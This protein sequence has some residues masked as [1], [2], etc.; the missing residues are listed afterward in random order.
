M[1]K[2]TNNIDRVT[3][4]YDWAKNN[5]TEILKATI[6][7][8]TIRQFYNQADNEWGDWHNG[9]YE[10]IS[11]LIDSFLEINNQAKEEYINGKHSRGEFAN[12]VFAKE[13]SKVYQCYRFLKIQWL[14]NSIKQD[15]QHAPIQLMRFRDTQYRFHPGSDKIHSLYM[16]ARQKQLPVNL[17]YIWYKDLDPHLPSNID[18]DV[19]QT[20]D[21]FAKMF[22]KFND[23]RFKTI[24][25]HA[26]INK[27]DWTT[28]QVHFNVFC[29]FVS[30]V[31]SEA[32]D[33]TCQ[34]PF[35]IRHL[36][37][38]DSVHHD[39]IDIKGTDLIYDY[40]LQEE[41]GKQCFTFSNGIKYY[42]VATP[43]EWLGYDHIWI[44]ET[45][46]EIYT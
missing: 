10:G 13:D 21:E 37:Y 24:E 31:L 39:G 4:F 3:N 16:L 15:C 11:F 18:F 44:P 43:K 14:Y 38:N 7:A 40:T 45:D 28:D 25:G 33:Y 20:P 2:S 35:D 19:V 17:F 8:E 12:K 9:L 36:S 32:N 26:S 6:D 23:K 1:E 46:Y 22:V 30:S 42:K 34:I 5:N 29:R 41:N 27:E